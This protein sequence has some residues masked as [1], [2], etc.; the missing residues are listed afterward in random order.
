MP[1]GLAV[2]AFLQ[3]FGTAVFGRPALLGGVFLAATLFGSGRFSHIW[4]L[5]TI[6]CLTLKGRSTFTGV[7]LL[8]DLRIGLGSIRKGVQKLLVSTG[9][10]GG[11]IVD[12]G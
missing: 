2:V 10:R 1:R 3:P 8:W 5:R 4:K 12:D 7:L 9:N 11:M 6:H